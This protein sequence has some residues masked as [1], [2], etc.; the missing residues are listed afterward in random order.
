LATLQPEWRDVLTKWD[1]DLALLATEA[2][3]AHEL[4][5]EPGWRVRF[6]DPTAVL[7]ERGD[8]IAQPQGES[9]AELMTCYRA[10]ESA[11]HS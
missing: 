8:T 3:L 7:L 9:I 2:P 6:C 11:E 1:I 4:A 5:R 10:K